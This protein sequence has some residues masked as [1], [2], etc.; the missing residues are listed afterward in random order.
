MAT[1]RK[2]TRNSIRRSIRAAR[3]IL[4]EFKGL[5][6]DLALIL[7]ATWGLLHVARVLFVLAR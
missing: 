3:A 4:R 2:E 7:A 5:L 6:E 1:R